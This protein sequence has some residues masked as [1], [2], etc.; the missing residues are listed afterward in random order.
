MYDT[1]AIDQ[2]KL[3]A[4]PRAATGQDQAV[5]ETVAFPTV[6]GPNGLGQR[7]VGLRC[8]GMVGQHASRGR[9]A[10]P[11][12]DRSARFPCPASICRG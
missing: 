9:R 7:T 4:D 3:A 1:Q 5:A 8:G 11:A 6:I 2:L 12:S 10:R